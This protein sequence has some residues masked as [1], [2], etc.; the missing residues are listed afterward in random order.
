MR[1]SITL[2]LGLAVAACGGAED[3]QTAQPEDS[4][5]TRPQSEM[6]AAEDSD[7]AAVGVSDTTAEGIV[8]VVGADPSPQVVLSAGTATNPAPVFHELAASHLQAYYPGEGDGLDE[9][10]VVDGC[11]DKVAAYKRPKKVII[12]GEDEMP[13]TATGKILHRI[14]RERYGNE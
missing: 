5:T 14:L 9:K 11:R 6:R 1:F 13:R 12:I 4:D 7:G 2:A 3:E 8:Q 10:T